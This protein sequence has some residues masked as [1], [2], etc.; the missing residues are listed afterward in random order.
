RFG[1]NV[2]LDH[3][4]PEEGLALVTPSPRTVSI[5]LMTRKEFQP[6]TII[7]L[8]AASWIQFMLHDWI[9]H[10]NNE[11]ENPIEVPLRDGDDWPESERPMVV[12]RTRRDPTRPPG[13]TDKR[14][15]FVNT[16]THWW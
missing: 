16:E 2:P 8:L 13:D 3:I 5:E 6:A 11:K 1:R 7:N 12:R 9:S 10:G 15:T 14:P 4:T